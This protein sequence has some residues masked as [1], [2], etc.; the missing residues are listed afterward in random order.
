MACVKCVVAHVLM[1]VP[2]Q[3]LIHVH[4]TPRT[5]Q[6]AICYVAMLILVHTMPRAISIATSCAQIRTLVPWT[7]KMIMTATQSVVM[8][9][10]VAM[11]LLTISTAIDCVSILIVWMDL[12]VAVTRNQQFSQPSTV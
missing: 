9:T 8:W 3:S 2:H 6:T 10:A 7:L 12:G 5:T 1:P 11:T 4:E